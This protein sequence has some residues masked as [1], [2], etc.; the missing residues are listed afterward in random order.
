MEHINSLMS[1]PSIQ[2][3]KVSYHSEFNRLNLEDLAL[4]I[5]NY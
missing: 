4:K 5:K 1:L 2:M 3:T